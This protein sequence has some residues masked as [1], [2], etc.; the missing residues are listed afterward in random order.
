MQVIKI[1]S[2]NLAIVITQD[3][4][5][6]NTTFGRKNCLR[7]WMKGKVMQISMQNTHTIGTVILNN[8]FES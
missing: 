1:L 3:K 6:Q 4:F 8:N 2:E 7:R 5:S